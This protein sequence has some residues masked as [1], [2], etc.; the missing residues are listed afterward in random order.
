MATTSKRTF[1]PRGSKLL[2]VAGRVPSSIAVWLALVAFLA[3]VKVTLD[4]FFP[5][6]FA[7]PDQAALFQWASLAAIS[8]AGLIGVVLSRRTG[9]PEAWDERISNRQRILIPVLLGLA[10]SVIPVVLD[11]ATH[12]TRLI[13]ARHGL[14]QQYTGF[15]PMLL[16]FTGGAIIVEVV[17][18][19]LPIPLLLWLFSLIL[20]R[21]G[22][23][24]IFWILA[25]LTS[26]IEPLTSIQDMQVIPGLVMPVVA[27]NIYAFN[28]AQAAMFRKYGFLAAILVRA[29][30]YVVWH[31]VYI[32]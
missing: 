30:F 25:V 4:L 7:A 6:A 24:R 23:E 21:K 19:L 22:Q 15:I 31:A 16:G 12:Y 14:A 20:K 2:A 5:Y 3:I 1:Q 13:D 26:A 17:Y 27:A 28:F 9:F 8:V 10:F 18:R 29:A 11:S 32:H